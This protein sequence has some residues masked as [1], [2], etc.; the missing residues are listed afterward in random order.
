MVSLFLGSVAGA[1][2]AVLPG[3]AGDF[4]MVFIAVLTG[5]FS[6]VA[7]RTRIVPRWVS[8]LGAVVA[9]AAA[10]GTAGVTLNSGVLYGFWFG[11]LYGWVLWIPITGIVLAVRTRRAAAVVH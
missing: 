11:G 7:W 1:V 4:P 2:L 3:L 6:L 5:A 10:L 9:A 8:V